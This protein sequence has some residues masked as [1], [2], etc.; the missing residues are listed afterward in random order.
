MRTNSQARGRLAR[1][2]SRSAAGSRVA[3]CLALVAALL[4]ANS[5][6]VNNPANA[7]PG[8]VTTYATTNSNG[9]LAVTSDGTV[10]TADAYRISRISSNGT[11]TDVAGHCVSGSGCGGWGDGNG[12][13]AAFDH[14]NSLAVDPQGNLIVADTE[15][16]MIRKFNPTTL[17]VTT[18]AGRVS[19]GNTLEN[20]RG[21]QDD[22]N[23]L[24]AM[25]DGPGHVAVDANGVIYVSDGNNRRVRKISTDGVTTLAGTGAP[26]STDGANGT[27]TPG[28]IAVDPSGNVIVADTDGHVRKISPSGVLSTIA[29]DGTTG[30][31]DSADPLQAKFGFI[32]GIAV[33]SNGDIYISDNTNNRIRKISASGGVSTYAGDGTPGWVDGERSI[34]QFYKSEELDFSPNGDLYIADGISA[35]ERIRKI[36][37]APD[38]TPTPGDVSSFIGCGHGFL[39][40]GGYANIG[41]VD[42]AIGQD[43][44]VYNLA[45][46]RVHK[47]T[48]DDFVSLLAGGGTG[49]ADGLGSA[50]L[51]D[52]AYAIDVDPNGNL[53]VADFNNRRIRKIDPAGNVSTF[54]GGSLATFDGTNPDYMDGNGG[55]A[56]FSG[57]YG[58]A[59]DAAGN[60][61][62]ADT[63]FTFGPSVRKVSPSGQVTTI[64]GER[65]Y[66]DYGVQDRALDGPVAQARFL[67]LKAI[68]VN[69]AGT[70]IYVT[71]GNR[72][73][74]IEGGIVTTV[75]GAFDAGDQVGTA[76]NA[77]FDRPAGLVI[78]GAGNVFVSDTWNHRVKKIDTGGMVTLVAGSGTG[79]ALDGS[80]T[81]A[82][83]T[84]P[85]GLAID[86]TGSLLVSSSC[87]RRIAGVA[88][89][90]TIGGGGSTDSS[91][92]TSSS[93]TSSSSTSSS[94]TSSSTTSTST[95]TTTTTT[96]AGSNAASNAA[97]GGGSGEQSAQINPTPVPPVAPPAGPA[98]A[99]APA[100]NGSST[101]TTAPAAPSV[102]VDPPV[103]ASNGGLTVK[104]AGLL[105]GSTV[106]VELHS[107]V[108]QLG[109]TTVRSDGTFTFEVPS[110]PPVEAGAHSIV[111]VGV[112]ASNQTVQLTTSLNVL[113]SAVSSSEP[114]AAPALPATTSTVAFTGAN[115]M[116]VLATA[117]L[118]LAAGFLLVLS[119]P[120]RKRG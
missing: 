61:Y 48:N 16:H 58:L 111:A 51:F 107:D 92:S 60:V 97:A 76:A 103:V 2:A 106:T 6:V 12:L 34:A 55:A 20:P 9:A 83:F 114:P 108:V 87:V 89:A 117:L 84:Y 42:V 39:A 19:V 46:D 62:V 104:G 11:V 22:P 69:P 110:L 115:T 47:R 80:P 3:G 100:V 23:P 56:R 29:G 37:L 44:T 4:T 98:P 17:A 90:P 30:Y 81:A 38:P 75:A 25:F 94:T 13:G 50:A 95:S 101:T 112:N 66:V 82:Q 96:I 36:Q 70:V 68:A 57:A 116:K 54:A 113:G 85:A 118:L 71:D 45:P 64:A 93:S 88:S 15:N 8:A 67:D 32:F 49:F 59:V 52:F 5:L 31:K 43:G 102:V 105:P 120:R 63:A 18:I 21:F 78:D 33:A 72:V 40:D 79:G 28:P 119:G 53:F 77:R 86:S 14:I 27:I 7:T 24:R 99:P 65:D 74:K 26:G 10:Y 41:S 35:S 73:R 1:V 91:S 109:K